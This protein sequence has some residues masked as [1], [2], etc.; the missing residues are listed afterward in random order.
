MAL[1]KPQ[2]KS[3][4]QPKQEEKETVLL[5]L[6]L[7]TNYN[8][9][10]TIFQKGK[11]YK[12]NKSDAINLLGQQDHAERQIWKRY[13]PPVRIRKKEEV[14]DATQVD[15]TASTEDAYPDGLK[16]VEP[17]KRIEVG[18]DD[19]IADVLAEVAKDPENVTV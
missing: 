17:K 9:H 16:S 5:E 19:E 8:W 11:A 12:F 1:N 15:M 6:A 14:L 10:G 2:E 13:A 4:E 7:Y 18:T 3:V